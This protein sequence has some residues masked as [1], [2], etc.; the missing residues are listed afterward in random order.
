MPEWVTLSRPYNSA[1]L[2][3]SHE[4]WSMPVLLLVLDDACVRN[5]F[6]PIQ[7]SYTEN[8]FYID[9]ATLDDAGVCDPFVPT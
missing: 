3:V 7:R 9:A 2:S 1:A 4:V 6:V 5:D 8:L